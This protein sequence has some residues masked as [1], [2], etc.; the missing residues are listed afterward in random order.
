LYTGIEKPVT[1]I[2]AGK[3]TS[4]EFAWSFSKIQ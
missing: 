3:L 2:R 1:I 4:V